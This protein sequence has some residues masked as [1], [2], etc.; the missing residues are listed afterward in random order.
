MTSPPHTAA[1]PVATLWYRPKGI[2]MFSGDAIF[3]AVLLVLCALSWY[4]RRQGSLDLRW[5]ASVYYVLGTSLA[6][7]TGYRL[8]NE[9]GE[10]L[11]NQYPPLLPTIIAA[12]Q[13]LAG[14]TDPFV[15]GRFLKLTFVLASC[16]IVAGTYIFLRLFLPPW[17]ARSAAL[18][19]VVNVST[20]LYFNMLSA[21]L[22]FTAALV[23]FLLAHYGRR[24]AWSEILAAIAA[25]AAFLT[26]T[27]GLVIFA[28]WIG[29]ALLRRQFSRAAVRSIVA[30][31]C[32]LPW[33]VYI[34]KV[35][36]S[37]EYSQPAYAYQ[38][39]DYLCYN[40]SYARNMTYVDPF[41][42]ELG[43]VSAP[44]LIG[45][46]TS[47]LISI[48]GVVAQTVTSYR[49]FWIGQIA[50]LSFRTGLGVVS[51]R[52][53]DGLLF[54][55]GCFVLLGIVVLGVRGEWFIGIYVGATL[56]ALCTTPWP[57][58]YVRYLA[59]STP[60]LLL[61][62]LTA[63]RKTQDLWAKRW[64][65]MGRGA[66]C[67]I[68]LILVEQT[69]TYYR[70]H[71]TYL[72][73]SDVTDNTGTP[74]VYKQ[75]FYDADNVAMDECITWIAKHANRNDVISAS[76]AHWVYLRTGRKAVVPP[77]A[78]DATVANR[79]LDSVP[80]RYII[81]ESPSFY[82]FRYVS[83]AVQDSTKW[84]LVYVATTYDMRVYERILNH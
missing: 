80:V 14:T 38:R 53:V 47:N 60:I 44:D 68:A 22:P 56:I 1:N 63:L 33:Y 51:P 6:Q 72:T 48:P 37:T 73:A 46:L 74:I 17:W 18:L 30:A 76:M 31:V 40:V 42:P 69:A 39:A 2:V 35:E 25:V 71:R 23:L 7:G 57:A 15:I 21:E 28:A 11:A 77:L 32:V 52:L 27:V 12:H 5:D 24:G 54:I 81:R 59:P 20:H 66:I 10:I 26:R 70:A 41:R 65:T 55:I 36:S 64:P 29:D 67:V 61:G 19:Y 49:N 4:P 13:K 8:L 9:P 78:A 83:N 50:A 84:R 82:G 3:V 45:R 43:K 62:L 16:F 58:Q 79:L 34:H 75:L